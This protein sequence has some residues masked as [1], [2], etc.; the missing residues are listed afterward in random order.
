LND[1]TVST[2]LADRIGDNALR[3]SNRFFVCYPERWVTLTGLVGTLGLAVVYLRGV[4]VRRDARALFARAQMPLMVYTAVFAGFTL[5]DFQVCDDTMPFALVLAF[6]IAAVFSAGLELIKRQQLVLAR[7]HVQ[8]LTAPAL[9]VLLLPTLN[10]FNDRSQ[11][12]MLTL[13]QQAAVAAQ[14]APLLGPD[15]QIQQLGDAGLLM[16][17]H[18]H[19][20]TK[21]IFFG[22][23]T[24]TGVLQQI[25]GGIEGVI[26]QLEVRRPKLV[27][28]SHMG[29]RSD[30]QNVFFNWLNQH[31]IQQ[32]EYRMYPGQAP[33][34]T[35]YVRND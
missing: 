24:G 19:N 31:Y 5:L 6:G 29:W 28:L 8:Y 13:D 34:L 30:W 1:K 7:E 18:R 21:L 16:F 35:V 17:L 12:N 27:A 4:L 20:T 26:A 2:C 9:V 23:K 32:G 22:P 3:L 14:I 11:R 15:D 25:P 33:E 10:A